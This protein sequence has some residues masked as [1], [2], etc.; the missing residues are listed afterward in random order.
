YDLLQPLQSTSL[1]AFGANVGGPARAVGTLSSRA[2]STPAIANVTSADGAIRE[3]TDRRT[4]G[5]VQHAHRLGQIWVQDLRD[6][7][8]AVLALV[9]LENGDQRAAHR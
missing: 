9:V 7:H 2:S 5:G 1:T 6:R 8:A 3:P 4:S